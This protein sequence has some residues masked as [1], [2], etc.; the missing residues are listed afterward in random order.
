[1]SETRPVPRRESPWGLLEGHREPKA[2]RCNDRV[3]DVVQI[4]FEALLPLTH[5]EEINKYNAEEFM[6][7]ASL[8]CTEDQ[9]SRRHVYFAEDRTLIIMELLFS[10]DGY[11]KQISPQ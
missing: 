6:I 11:G 7:T 3:E 9:P 2:H 10:D 5:L 1:M 4:V 8:Q